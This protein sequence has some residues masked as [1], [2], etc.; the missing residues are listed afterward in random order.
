M[1]DLGFDYYIVKPPRNTVIRARYSVVQDWFVV[2]T[3]KS[4]CCI[5]GPL[6]SMTLPTWWKP[7]EPGDAEQLKA[8]SKAM[9][10][11]LHYALRNS[12]LIE[13]KSQ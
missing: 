7:A 5:Y 6:G 10:E 11:A 3:C 2:E 8:D 1:N 13:K 12:K 9:N 4:G